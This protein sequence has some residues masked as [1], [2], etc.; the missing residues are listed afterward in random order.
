[1]I[2]KLYVIFLLFFTIFS[3]NSFAKNSKEEFLTIFAEHESA[4]SLI[5]ITKKYSQKNNVIISIN[6]DNSADLIRDI[7]DG[8]PAGIFI[9]SHP[10]WTKQLKNKGLIDY[11]N[12]LEFSKMD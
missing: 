10:E 9:S 4:L 3:T 11:K 2:E 8:E 6:F 12:L 5:E 7:E 1:M